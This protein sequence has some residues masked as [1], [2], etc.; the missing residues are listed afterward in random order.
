MYIQTFETI[1]FCAAQLVQKVNDGHVRRILLH[2]AAKSHIRSLFLETFDGYY[3]CAPQ[4]WSRADLM[5][6]RRTMTR[7]L[8]AVNCARVELAAEREK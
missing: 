1:S 5:D 2:S 3:Y 6:A 7:S 4:Q 8:R